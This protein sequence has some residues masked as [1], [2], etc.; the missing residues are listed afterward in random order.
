VRPIASLVELGGRISNLQRLKTKSGKVYGFFVLFDYS[1]LV[2][3]FVPWDKYGLLGEVLEE[4]GDVVVRGRVTI[5]DERKVCEALEVKSA[6][7]GEGSGGEE[8]AGEDS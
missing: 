4:G 5:R 1:A 2:Q 8:T 3:V 6:S 7:E